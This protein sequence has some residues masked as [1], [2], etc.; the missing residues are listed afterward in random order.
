MPTPKAATA[1]RRAELVS[2]V[3]SFRLSKSKFCTG[4]QCLKALHF[5]IHAP[6]LASPIDGAQ[7]MI[8]DQGNEVGVEA[9]R[10]YP[11]GILIDIDRRE[12]DAAVVATQEA[13]AHSPAAI[14][15]GA[16]FF[17]H[18]LVRPDILKNN[19][20][21]TWDLIEVKSSTERKPEHIFDLAIQRYVIEGGGLRIRNCFLK[22][23][24]RECVFPNLDNLFADT[25]CNEEVVK[26]L[27]TIPARIEQMLGVLETAAAPATLI[28]PQCDSPYECRF[29]PQCWGHIPQHSIFELNGV[30]DKTKFELYA[31]GI[32]SIRDIPEGE[33]VSR[34]KPAQLQAVRSDT[35][36]ADPKG[37][38]EFL[39]RL[40]YP[41]Y[42]LDFETINPAIPQ[43][44]GTRPYTQIPFQYSCHV[45]DAPD[46][47]PRHFEFLAEGQGDPRTDLAQGLVKVLGTQGTILAYNQSFEKT[48]IDELAK[49]F[50]SLHNELK[51]L[52][53]RF[54]D[55]KDAFAKHYYHPDF[56]GSFSIKDVLPVLVPSMSYAGLAVNNG[57]S[58]QVAYRQ[59]GEPN[60]TPSQRE[61]IRG[62]LLTYCRQDTLAMVELLTWLR[63]YRE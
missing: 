5:L 35:P 16:F 9:R 24:N 25:N 55:L 62:D 1:L 58:A 54:I 51:A 14:F 33:K 60:L 2:D 18:T 46:A 27:V 22:H 15:E 30:W 48:R 32:V 56:H 42:F 7:Q 47:A 57:G 52:L 23:L 43:Y 10:R 59:L 8:F 53:P 40:E 12:A 6:E 13:L 49:F 21:G 3:G 34:A 28:G 44:V 63:N 45:V 37:L 31:R 41:L 50:P 4:V 17:H 11:G 61:K 39:S 19:G 20:D 36:V 38:R 26:E 29:K